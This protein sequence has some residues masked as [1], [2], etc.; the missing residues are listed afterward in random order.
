MTTKH[1]HNRLLMQGVQPAFRAQQTGFTLIELIMVIVILGILSAFALPKFADF[2]DD[3]ENSSIEGAKG[4]VRSASAITHAACLASS[5]CNASGA[6]STVTMEGVDVDMVYGYPARTALTAAANLDG[7]YINTAS[8]V[9][10]VALEQAAGSKCFSYANATE[11][12]GEITAPA[13][14]S[15]LTYTENGAGA[16]DDTCQ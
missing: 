8:S 6:T 9:T 2:S 4:S 12:G 11:S 16:A 7:Y 10:I 5:G 1:F 15:I 14:S 13:I 3:A